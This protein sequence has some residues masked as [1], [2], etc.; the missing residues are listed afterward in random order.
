[1]NLS[2]KHEVRFGELYN[3]CACRLSDLSS[4]VFLSIAQAS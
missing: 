1:M 3:R 4:I 2:V